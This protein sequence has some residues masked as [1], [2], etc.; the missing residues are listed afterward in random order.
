MTTEEKAAKITEFQDH[1]MC[2]DTIIRH[3]L[4]R[5]LYTEGVHHIAEIA[6]CW[7]LVDAVLLNVSRLKSSKAGESFYVVQL[8]LDEG[9]SS[10]VLSIHTDTPSKENQVWKQKLD[11]TDFPMPEFKFYLVRQDANFFLM[12]LPREY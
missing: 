8:K 10:G 12:M 5:N 6:G 11:Y 1:W 4:S 9:K 7:W 2:G 3:P